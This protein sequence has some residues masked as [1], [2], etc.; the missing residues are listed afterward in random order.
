MR[1][2]MNI[3]RKKVLHVFGNIGGGHHQTN[4]DVR[5]NKKIV[6]QK[7]KKTL[8]WKTRQGNKRGVVPLVRYSGPFLNG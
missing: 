8:K 1:E 7:N 2:I 5:K 6:P 4:S 3:W